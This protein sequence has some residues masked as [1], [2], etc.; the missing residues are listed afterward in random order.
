VLKA[1]IDCRKRKRR[2]LSALG[3]ECNLEKNIEGLTQALQKRTYQPDRSVYFVVTK[4]K[5]REIFASEFVDRITHHLLINEVEKIWEK[6]IFIPHSCACRKGKG[7]HY[8]MQK[9]ACLAKEYRYYGQFDISNFF[10]SIDKEILFCLFS[11]VIRQQSKPDF[12]KEE[13]LWLAEVIIFTDPTLN[14][15]HK[16]DR[17]LRLLVPQ[18]KSLFNQEPEIGMP[19]G[20]LSSQFLANVYLHEL[21]NYVLEVLKIPGYIRYVDDFVLAC[22]TKK[23]ITVARNKIKKFLSDELA[24]T[25]HPKKQQI[26]PTNHGIPFVGY[27]IKPTG[28]LV[29]RNVVRALKNKI[30]YYHKH[31]PG[32][33]SRLASSLNSYYGHFKQARSYNLRRHLFE[34]H[35]PNEIKYQMWVVG[36]WNYF[37]PVKKISPRYIQARKKLRKKNLP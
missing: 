8:A 10:S 23:E 31:L 20:N 11:K 26:Q 18:Q 21:D 34:K 24:M 4:P 28:V 15:F 27:F 19:I 16:G 12:W 2:T 13:I 17:R 1:Y 37:K 25:L 36:Q 33:L 22:N 5:P 7:H 3:F 29:R 9:M 30:Y 14:Y 35:L 32:D 6:N